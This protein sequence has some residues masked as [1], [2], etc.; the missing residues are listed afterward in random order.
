MRGPSSLLQGFA[1]PR[2]CAYCNSAGPLTREHVW[3][4]CI[5]DRLPTYKARF[6]GRGKAIRGD[7]TVADVCRTCNH[8]PL[9]KLDAYICELF[10]RYFIHLCERGASIDFEY[11]W[12]K[13]GS[14]FLKA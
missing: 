8:G 11:D 13:L 7:V 3:P 5:I 6:T 12:R 9:S 1:M 2:K 4:S 10:D 14:W